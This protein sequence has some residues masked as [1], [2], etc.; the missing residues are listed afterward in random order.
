MKHLKSFNESLKDK[1][2]PKTEDEILDSL[3]DLTP[4][5]MILKCADNGYIRGIELALDRG[6]DINVRSSS[7]GY[8]PL[9]YAVLSSN[10]ALV[11]YLVEKGADLNIN[12]KK[13]N[14]AL[15]IA[16]GHSFIKPSEDQLPIIDILLDAGI[17][18]FSKNK[19]GYTAL[20]IAVVKGK[21]DVIELLLDYGAW[22]DRATYKNLFE[23]V[24]LSQ[25]DKETIGKIINILK[26][27]K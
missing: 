12:D 5:D 14:N 15:L 3:K 4:D 20:Y 9:M 10:K 16:I 11:E 2:I 6:A 21:L 7:E 8:T 17:N 23:W 19:F 18:I 26:T 27:Y 24:R 1:M 25:L 13:K 22:K